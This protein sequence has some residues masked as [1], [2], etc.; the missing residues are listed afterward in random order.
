TKKGTPTMGGLLIILA[1]VLPTLLWADLTNRYVRIAVASTLAFGVIGFF[2]DYLKLRKMR[3]LGL[4]VRGKMAVQILVAGILGVYLINLAPA[5]LFTTQ[6]SVPFFK[7]WT[8]D[9]G[10]FYAPFVIVVVSGAANAVNL[11]DGL[12]GL[13][14]GSVLIASGTFSILTYIA[15]NAVASTYLGVINVK[16]TGELTVFCGALVGASLG[17]LWF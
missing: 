3:S 8:P 10:W 4:S 12:D 14:I 11:T 2:D 1:A 9:L 6:F 13:A 16:G 17:F 5:D 7:R 15:G